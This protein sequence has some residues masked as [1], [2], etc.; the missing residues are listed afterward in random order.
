M[1]ISLVDKAAT[2]REI[3]YK[4]D[5]RRTDASVEKKDDYVDGI[6]AM[7][8]YNA[9]MRCMMLAKE[10]LEAS[11]TPETAKHVSAILAQM[12]S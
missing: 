8:Q 5:T 7:A 2:M 11:P 9:R 10:L 3:V 4:R 6:M 12:E 1:E